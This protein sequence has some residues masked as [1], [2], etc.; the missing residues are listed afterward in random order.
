MPLTFLDIVRAKDTVEDANKLFLE[1][2]K[3]LAFLQFNRKNCRHVPELTLEG[4]TYD[5]TGDRFFVNLSF[6][7][8]GEKNYFCVYVPTKWVDEGCIPKE[9]QIQINFAKQAFFEASK[10]EEDYY[11]TLKR[12]RDM[13]EYERIKKLYDL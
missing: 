12:E 2:A 1:F 4:F 9:M 7:D 13:A 11:T 3:E 10:K 6:Y 8:S 5:K